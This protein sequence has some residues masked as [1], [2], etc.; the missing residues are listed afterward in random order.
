MLCLEEQGGGVQATLACRPVSD[1]WPPLHND[2]KDKS[3]A[4]SSRLYAE[5]L[6]GYY[7]IENEK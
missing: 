5:I 2:S 7:K 3:V 4:Y 1:V 6:L